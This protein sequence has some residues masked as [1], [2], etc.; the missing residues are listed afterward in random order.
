MFGVPSTCGF[1]RLAPGN[2]QVFGREALKMIFM[3]LVATLLYLAVIIAALGALLWALVLTANYILGPGFVYL[4]HKVPAR[5]ALEAASFE[6]LSPAIRTHLGVD[7]RALQEEGFEISS[8][9]R[10]PRYVPREVMAAFV[11]ANLT[12][13]RVVASCWASVMAAFVSANLSLRMLSGRRSDVA[14]CYVLMLNG[15]TQER[16]TVMALRGADVALPRLRAVAV[17]FLTGFGN[18]RIVRTSNSTLMS[19]SAEGAPVI[20]TALPEAGDARSLLQMHRHICIAAAS[21]YP[22]LPPELEAG[23]DYLAR[24]MAEDLAQQQE[25]GLLVL[26]RESGVLRPS[27]KGACLLCW[28]QLWPV[29][30]VRR[31]RA[32]GAA[33]RRLSGFE[34]ASTRSSVSHGS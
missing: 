27:W 19:N 13:M 20:E 29:S 9:V 8:C 6:E 22:A 18:G 3:L 31:A 28:S 15:S 32:K 10:Q 25:L 5:P 23:V 30:S 7:V 14:A 4:S 1:I 34:P 33:S 17:E 24:V 11:S 12:P 16:A 21:G 2:N 26:D